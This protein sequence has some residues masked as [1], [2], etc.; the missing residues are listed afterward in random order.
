MIAKQ[1]NIKNKF[2]YFY[3]DLI[4]VLNFGANNLKLDKKTW[5]NLD[6]YYV[7]KKPDWNVNSVNPLYLMINRFYGHIEEENG[8]KYL[9]IT[10]ISNNSDVLKKYDQVFSGIKYYIS[11]NSEYEKDYKK[12]KC[13]TD[14]D[15]PLNK[16][17]YFPT[18]TVII[19]CV[20][21][22]SGKY[23]HKFT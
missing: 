17:I 12:I 6:I 11:N 14:D 9:I 13:L 21:E 8:N 7:D 20:F 19:R 16:M 22:K 1:L 5:M 15:I 18:V 10:D 4:N 3:N 2:Y 23:Y